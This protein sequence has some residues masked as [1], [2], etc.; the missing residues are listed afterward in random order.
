V[1]SDRPGEVILV[2]TD[3][4]S[5][6]D[7]VLPMPIPDKGKLL[8]SLSLWSRAEQTSQNELRASDQEER[9]NEITD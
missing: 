7:V 5:V 9:S 2:A 3:R 1:Y 8:T 4:V 6:Y